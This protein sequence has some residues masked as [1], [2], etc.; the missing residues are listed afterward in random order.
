MSG[1]LQGMPVGA[2]FSGS[3]ANE[4]AGASSKAAG[5]VAAG[6]IALLMLVAG[7]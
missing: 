7:H 3:S 4:D 1:A 5:L 6:G 2:G